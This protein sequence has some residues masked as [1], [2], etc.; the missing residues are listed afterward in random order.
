MGSTLT[1]ALALGGN[2][3]YPKVS[4]QMCLARATSINEDNI[5]CCVGEVRGAE[6]IDQ[7]LLHLDAPK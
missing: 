6:L 5:L 2:A 1:F 7:L 4:S 3:S